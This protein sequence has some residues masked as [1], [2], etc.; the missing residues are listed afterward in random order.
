MA[1]WQY[2]PLAVVLCLGGR[3]N[4]GTV[5]RRCGLLAVVLCRFATADAEAG[6]VFSPFLADGRSVSYRFQLADGA[7]QGFFLSQSGNFV[8]EEVVEVTEFG[9]K[10]RVQLQTTETASCQYGGCSYTYD[11]WDYTN[12]S[13]SV[14]DCAAAEPWPQEMC[15]GEQACQADSQS[16]MQHFKSYNGTVNVSGTSY[17]AFWGGW[18][19]P[20]AICAVDMTAE[21]CVPVVLLSVDGTLIQR[22]SH[23]SYSDPVQPN[24]FS[25]PESCTSRPLTAEKTPTVQPGWFGII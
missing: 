12:G 22:F 20:P 7:G 5:L 19:E 24:A 6:C 16:A 10:S 17:P 8:V 21:T 11:R 3:N 23:F 4:P 9:K 13:S 25:P 1:L 2:L 15:F 18:Y 14:V